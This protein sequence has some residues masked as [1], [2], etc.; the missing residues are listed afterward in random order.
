MASGGDGGAGA[1]QQAEADR[2]ARINA[3]VEKI[4]A[5]FDSKPMSKGVNAATAFDQGASY[6]NEDGSAYVAPTST[7]MVPVQTAPGGGVDVTQGVYG[8]APQ[9]GIDKNAVQQAIAGGKLFTGVETITPTQT[10]QQLY[11]QQKQAVFDINKLDV[12]KQFKD[13]ERATR[14]GLARSGLAGGSE[15]V[16]ANARLL[17]RNNEGLI[18]ATGL[19]DQAAAD[20]KTADE[21][22][23]QSLISMAQSGID[24]GTAQGM[25]LRNL[26]ANA[27]TAAGNRAGATIGNLFGDLGQAYMLRQTSAGMT[28]G[29]KP[30]SQWYGVSNPQQTYGGTTT[31]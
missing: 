20:L 28:A 30:G 9:Q 7:E 17:E 31:R 15:D 1:A 25:A 21:R 23:R 26:D 5:I 8:Y 11:D 29:A 18:R 2:Q 24:T 22:S 6:Y 10:R 4:N 14:F 27:Q 12:D 16:D 3:A 13:A 19:G